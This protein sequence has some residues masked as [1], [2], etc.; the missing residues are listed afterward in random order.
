MLARGKDN[1]LYGSA[2]KSGTVIMSSNHQSLQHPKSGME[3]VEVSGEVRGSVLSCHS[4]CYDV[5]IKNRA[6]CG[7]L[8]PKRI[9]TNIE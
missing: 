6:C 5:Y 3:T 4:I 8:E 7:K 9:L 2:D 1:A